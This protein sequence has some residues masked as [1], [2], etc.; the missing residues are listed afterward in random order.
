MTNHEIAD[1][2]VSAAALAGVLMLMGTI[3]RHGASDPLNRRF[4]FGLSMVALLLAGRVLFWTTGIGLFDTLTLVGAALIPLGVLLLTEGLLRRHAPRFFKW[5]VATG[6]VLFT[7]LAFLPGW[8]AEP[9]L[10]WSLFSYQLGVFL[11]VG[12]LVVMR[13]RSGLSSAEN[14]MVER[15]ALS[16]LLIIPAMAT[17]YRLDQIALPVRLGGIAILYM[18]WLSV[19]LGR[20][21]MSHGDTI[22]SFVVLTLSAMAA[23]LAIALIGN[24]DAA[25]TVQA[26]ALA[27]SATLLAAI[28][29]DAQTLKVEERR[30]SLIRHLAEGP[31]AD[32]K[33]FL[34]GLQDHVLVEGAL[35]LDRPDLADFDTELLAR[36]FA[37][38][39]V[40]SK[41]DAGSQSRL[42][43]AQ[44]EQLAWLFEKYDATHVLLA[45][46]KPF[47]LVALN[48]PA[49]SASPG[50]ESELH[51]M[52][53]MALL[54]SRQE[55]RA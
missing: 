25:H 5:A 30:D 32:T 8:F 50:A 52:Q 28:Y 19:G 16:L 33:A 23:G 29:N 55:A 4:L 10:S 37:I 49:L 53:R 14:R 44:K 17:D 15:I 36:L 1:T 20:T 45:A 47:T 38:R 9:W 34:R 18:C 41:E 27:L 13:D 42:A 31:I 12:W 46:E 11:G 54:I 26:M 21:Q 43:E 35:I 7:L 2:L 48:M 24:L 51:A 39:P 6:S 3:R 22:R 40:C